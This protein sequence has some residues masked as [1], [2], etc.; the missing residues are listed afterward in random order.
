[1]CLLWRYR[2]GTAVSA[3]AVPDC[4]AEVEAELC[5]LAGQVDGL[6]FDRLADTGSLED[7]VELQAPYTPVDRIVR[8]SV[9]D[10]AL[11]MQDFRPVW[12]AVVYGC[13]AEPWQVSRPCWPDGASRDALRE[14]PRAFRALDDVRDVLAGTHADALPVSDQPLYRFLVESAGLFADR[15]LHVRST[16]VP[17]SWRQ[18]FCLMAVTSLRFPDIFKHRAEDRYGFDRSTRIALTVL[19]ASGDPEFAAA[20]TFDETFDDPLSVGF[21]EDSAEFNQVAQTLLR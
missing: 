15:L 14:L 1:M 7:W 6:G 10:F 11:W 8:G 12:S 2:H 19:S 3:V 13:G 4:F 20:E 16:A 18:R 5:R 17:D 21:A 9:F